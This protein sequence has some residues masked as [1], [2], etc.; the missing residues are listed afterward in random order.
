MLE[1]AL[2][3]EWWGHFGH[4]IVGNH[5]EEIAVVVSSILI[6]HFANVILVAIF[7]SL[8]FVIERVRQTARAERA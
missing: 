6:N 2:Y 5:G 4:E 3:I 7:K 8:N 1:T